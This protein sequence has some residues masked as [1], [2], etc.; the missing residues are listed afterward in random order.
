MTEFSGEVHPLAAKCRIISDDEMA[1]L[2]ASITENGLKQPLTLDWLGRLA[3]GR[4]RLRACELAGVEP[5]F[6]TDPELTDDKAVARFVR[7]QN[8]NRRHMSKGEQAAVDALCLAAEGK[9]KNGRWVRGSSENLN[10]S[11]ELRAESGF[12]LDWAPDLLDQVAAGTLAIEAAYQ[13]AKAVEDEAKRD[14]RAA[15]LA[16]AQLADLREHRPDLADLVDADS[17]PLADAL[18]VR[19][20]ERADE[21]KRLRDLEERRRKFT[22]DLGMA[23]HYLAPLALYPERTEQLATDF[24]PKYLLRPIE[25]GTLTAARAAIAL[26][27]ETIA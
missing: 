2:V 8:V 9:R 12:I 19:D 3:D 22:A 20:K 13:S 10:Y 24:D 5:S 4:N 16:A 1:E 7:A 18:I 14:E 15:E 6:V 25:P 21:L 23:L 17:L 11:H 27:E 26:I